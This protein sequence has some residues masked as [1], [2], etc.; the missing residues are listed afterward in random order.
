MRPCHAWCRGSNVAVGW[1][2][3]LDGTGGMSIVLESALA[4]RSSV[5]PCFGSY[6]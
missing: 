1:L 3:D 5:E 4:R 2:Q 6:R